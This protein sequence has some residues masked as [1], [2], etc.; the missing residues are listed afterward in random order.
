ML[1]NVGLVEKTKG[2][3]N[4]SDVRLKLAVSGHIITGT[5]NPRMENVF[6][7]LYFVYK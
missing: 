1:Q 4:A 7:L 3:L 2:L 5:T 6:P